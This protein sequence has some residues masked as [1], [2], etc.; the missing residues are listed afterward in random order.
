MKDSSP[1]I[2]VYNAGMQ[3]DLERLFLKAY[4]D[5]ADAIFRHI[6]LRLGDRE[7]AR[8]LM[9]DTYMKAWEYLSGGKS[10][11]NM[12]AFLYRVANNL[13]IDTARR[14]KLRTVQSL[15]EMREEQGF[16]P[17]AEEDNSAKTNID[18]ERV[19]PV[20]QSI[21]ESLRTPLV[22]RYVDGFSPSEI[23]E[24][25]GI[26]AN[27]VSVRIHRGMEALRSRLPHEA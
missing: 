17:P 5:Y 14:R 6:A 27:V 20:L 13:I 19:L 16:D 15:E 1:P 3:P 9:Q 7:Q 12:R 10:V 8:E 21:D 4:D 11:Q 23:A 24:L 18:A 2:V 22:M 26:S 25:L